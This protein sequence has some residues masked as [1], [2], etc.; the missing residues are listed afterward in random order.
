VHAFRHRVATIWPQQQHDLNAL[1]EVIS[2][3]P[4][5]TTGAWQSSLRVYAAAALRVSRTTPGARPAGS[6]L[7][8]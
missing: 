7:G 8:R 2:A 3:A 1:N 4:T 6:V 5:G